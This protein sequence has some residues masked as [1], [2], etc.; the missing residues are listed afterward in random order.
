VGIYVGWRG[1]SVLGPGIEH[2]SIWDRKLAAEKVALGSVQELFALLHQYYLEHGCHSEGG[3]GSCATRSDVRMLTIGHSFGGLITH[4]ALAPRLMTAIV[5]TH[6]EGDAPKLPYAYSYGDFTV[7]VNPAFEGS[8]FEALA[9][10]AAR[11]RY[12]DGRN[13]SRK[14]QLPILLIAQSKGD[15]ATHTFFP[16]FRGA[17]TVFEHTEDAQRQ[18]NVHAVGWI[19]RYITHDLT[20]DGDEVCK[21]WPIDTKD[22]AL[23]LKTHVNAEMDLMQ[24]LR[25]RNYTALTG[26]FRLCDRL[27]VTPSA[28]RFVGTGVP[29]G[30][31]TPLWVMR[32][33]EEVIAN[34]N[35]FLNPR[36]QVF[37]RQMYQAILR[38]KDE[39]QHRGIAKAVKACRARMP[40]C[41]CESYVG[42]GTGTGCAV[43]TS[44]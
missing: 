14:A 4:R 20:Q 29:P 12:E 17:T 22:A 30:T 10:A 41:E 13:G 33:G 44:P 8:R 23:Q 26:E 5:E 1:D 15:V 3:D 28:K 35:D 16:L 7:L 42:R 38:E 19:E 31:Y 21:S 9:R 39:L 25:D 34:H 32:T 43:R 6:R 40:A 27:H 24:G 2:S 36:F 11:R 37:V 18:V